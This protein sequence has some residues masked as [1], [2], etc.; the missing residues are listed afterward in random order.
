MASSS[1][2]RNRFEPFVAN[3][4]EVVAIQLLF[5]EKQLDDESCD[6]SLK[7]FNPEFTH[8]FFGD[9][10]SVFGYKDL[11]VKLYYSAAKLN[12]FLDIK[13]KEKVSK[14]ETNGIEADEVLKTIADK[15]E[16]QMCQS[17]NDFRLQLSKESQFKPYGQLIKSFT[18]DY[19]IEDKQITRQFEIY[20]TDILNPG[21][22]AYHQKMQTFLWWFI[23]A[24]SY[25]D[26]DDDRWQYFVVYEKRSP[27]LLLGQTNGHSNCSDDY[28]YCFVGYATVYRYYAYPQRIRP[29]ISQFLILPPFQRCGIG[30][31]LLQAI[32]DNYMSD[33]DVY[34]ITV[35]DPSES[36][37]RI[38][39]FV[40]AKNC[41]KL[42]A[43]SADKLK[44]GWNEE[45]A[46]VAQSCLKINRRQSRRVY[47]ILRFRNT[48][49]SNDEE[50]KS[51]RLYVK[52]RLNAPLRK[53]M[54]D[55]Q[56]LEK[57]KKFPEQELE[58]I[59]QTTIPT[60]ES[61]IDLL[62]KQYKELEDEYQHIIER[63]AK[64]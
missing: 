35:E 56:K 34:D 14:D 25:I 3:A 22:D 59:K 4:N 39:D 16:I 26:A 63:L 11:K 40:D 17:M 20:M 29:R 5:N 55:I 27:N 21:F 18:I 46:K 32:Y 43:F 7:E 52:Q 64:S 45:L 1:L 54:I 31:A 23:D 42:E 47:E 12:C 30:S 48:N 62:D 2:I 38:R 28:L 10:E 19:K 8:Q 15:L 58:L 61:R 53:Q 9:N 36:F 24:V 6:I 50:Y 57:N 60:L 41:Q 13:Y 51:F 44:L 33:G 37:T 49:R